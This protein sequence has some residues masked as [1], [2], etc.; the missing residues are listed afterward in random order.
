MHKVQRQGDA[1]QRNQPRQQ[2]A[3]EG[4]IIACNRLGRRINNCY[5]IGSRKQ[6]HEGLD[7]D[8]E[9]VHLSES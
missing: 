6:R 3:D 4:R 2:F 8:T 5:A 7:D 9:L 1:G